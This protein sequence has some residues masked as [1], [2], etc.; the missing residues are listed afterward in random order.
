MF[1]HLLFAAQSRELKSLFSSWSLPATTNTWT[2]K[3][4]QHNR[5]H[6]PPP[7]FDPSQWNPLAPEDSAQRLEHIVAIKKEI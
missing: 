1:P 5:K 4:Q 6:Q 7:P 3:F 2:P